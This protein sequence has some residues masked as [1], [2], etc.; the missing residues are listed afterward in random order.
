MIKAAMCS[1]PILIRRPPPPPPPLIRCIH[2]NNEF[3]QDQVDD[4]EKSCPKM[5]RSCID[6]FFS[7]F[8]FSSK[9]K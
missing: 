4:H 6:R 7:F 3:P 5:P 9:K 8:G 2:C 1:N